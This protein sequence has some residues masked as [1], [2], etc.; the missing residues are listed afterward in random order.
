ML[1]ADQKAFYAENGYLKVEAAVTP[2]E[3]ARLREI[4]YRFIDGSRDVAQSDDVYDLDTGH[5]AAEP[6]LTRIKLPHRQD[7]YYW[8]IL[9]QSR[10]TQVLNDLLG[11]DTVLLT[12]KLNTKAP[13]GGAAVEWHQD[14]AFYPHTNDDL[15]A[16]GLMLEDVDEANGPLMVLPGSHRGP[17]LSHHANGVFCG[18]IDPDDPLFERDRVVTL[19]GKAGDMTVHHARTL[20]GSAPNMSDRN[21]LILFYECAAGDAWPLLGSSSYF[22]A[23]GQRGFWEDLQDRVITG[24]PCL[25]PRMADVPVV[26]PLPPAPDISSIFRMQESGGA[27]SAFR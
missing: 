27:K 10:V 8:Q 15:L 23:L 4:T 21:R 2:D 14:W 1:T 19:T 18:A 16:F 22:H 13:G 9:T 20:H 3:L 12:S 24:Q 17:V 7:P 6:R 26:M 25:T 11:P 5:S